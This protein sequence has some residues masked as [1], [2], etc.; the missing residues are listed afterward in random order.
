M[1]HGT[2]AMGQKN[3]PP[4]VAVR[5]RPVSDV[6]KSRDRVWSV[7]DSNTG[8]L[9]STSTKNPEVLTFYPMCHRFDRVFRDTADNREVYTSLAADAVKGAMNGKSAT[10]M[11]YGATNSGKTYTMVG[12][13]EDPGI[14]SPSIHEVFNEAQTLSTK[15]FRLTL[16]MMELYNECLKD[17][18]CPV[19]NNLHIMNGVD[20]VKIPKLTA[21]E[22]AVSKGQK[23][24]GSSINKSLLTLRTV[25]SKLG[26]EQ[27]PHVNFRDSKLTRFLQPSLC[28]NGNG[29]K[30]NIVLICTI[31]SIHREETRST[32]QFAF[33]AKSIRFPNVKRK[34]RIFDAK[35][36][37]IG[38]DERSARQYRGGRMRSGPVAKLVEFQAN[39]GCMS[40]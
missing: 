7:D 30:T 17:L 38:T 35:A 6:E 22:A 31:T 13:K 10:I 25:I 40:S 2:S 33:D 8:G 39:A 36:K 19:Q 1:E 5:L 23:Q 27:A 29:N 16:S 9:W 21:I 18:L 24:E 12:V 20:C 14:V 34:L 32:L 15:K 37:E 3:E 4:V 26:D 28:G 11:T